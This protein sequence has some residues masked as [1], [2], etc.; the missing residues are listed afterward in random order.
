M[1]Q[2]P[3]AMPPEQL[4]QL[5]LLNI[6]IEGPLPCFPDTMNQL[7]PGQLAR[8]MHAAVVFSTDTSEE[9]QCPI[10]F[11][12]INCMGSVSAAEG[13]RSGTLLPVVQAALHR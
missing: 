2:I 10:L 8:L 6:A 13:V 12:Y 9:S 7:T 4:H 3:H 1:L 5:M 11:H